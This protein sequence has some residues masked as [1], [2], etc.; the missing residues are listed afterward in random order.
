MELL[1]R[2]NTAQQHLLSRALP[3]IPWG[4]LSLIQFFN[5]PAMS[6]TREL[7]AILD[8]AGVQSDFCEWLEKEFM[9]AWG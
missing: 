8:G 7:L 3:P 4:L 6:T 9:N 2:S 5:L 1:F